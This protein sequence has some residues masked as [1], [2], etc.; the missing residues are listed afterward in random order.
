MTDASTDSILNL[1][2]RGCPACDSAGRMLFDFLAQFQYVVAMDEE[3]RRRHAVAGGFC[4]LHSWQFATWSSATGVARACEAMVE[5]AADALDEAFGATGGTIASALPVPAGQ[6]ACTACQVITEA[7]RRAIRQLARLIETEDGRMVYARSGGICLPDLPLL[8]GELPSADLRSWIITDASR[9]F[10]RLGADLRS[11]IDLRENKERSKL[12][13]DQ[14][15]AT[16]RALVH[17]VGAEIYYA[18]RRV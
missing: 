8:L 13:S 7:R 4:P 2:T 9:R 11:Y 3:T 10:R 17:L 15:D 12:T 14:L 1:E 18:D 6:P 16:V 5:H